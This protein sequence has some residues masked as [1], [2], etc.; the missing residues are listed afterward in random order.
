MKN[1]PKCLGTG[2]LSLDLIYKDSTKPLAAAGGSCGNVMAMLTSFGWDARPAGRIGED[3]AASILLHDLISLG[4]NTDFIYQDKNSHTPIILEFLNMSGSE[5]GH[6][7]SRTCHITQQKLPR[8]EALHDTE[9]CNILKSV[10][11]FDYYYF[12]RLDNNALKLASRFSQQGKPVFFEPQ[13]ISSVTQFLEVLPHVSVLKISD[14]TALNLSDALNQCLPDLTI[15]T[16]GKEGLSYRCSDGRHASIP[17][18]RNENVVDACGSGDW[19]SA[20]I[21]NEMFVQQITSFSVLSTRAIENV[22]FNS[23]MKSTDNLSYVGARGAMYK[24]ITPVDEIVYPFS[25]DFGANSVG[26]YMQLLD[27]VAPSGLLS[28]TILS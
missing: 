27:D 10:D 18:M 8:Y 23:Q 5:S 21:I 1:Q 16:H 24:Q 6:S 22:L 26:N 12:D 19:L 7:F 14:E 11:E 28:Q 3:L 15:V 4:V 25:I 13:K 17:A 9:I 20:S 2:L